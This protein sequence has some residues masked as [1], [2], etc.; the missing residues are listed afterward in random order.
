M[1][2]LSLENHIFTNHTPPLLH[3]NNSSLEEVSERGIFLKIVIKYAYEANVV[4]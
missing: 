1:I 3:L 4:W 2:S